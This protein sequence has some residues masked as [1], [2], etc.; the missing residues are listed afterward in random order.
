M[1]RC[2]C[3]LSEGRSPGDAHC[4]VPSVVFLAHCGIRHTGLF[5][6]S[7]SLILWGYVHDI[8]VSEKKQLTIQSLLYNSNFGTGMSV[9][10]LYACEY[11][12]RRKDTKILRV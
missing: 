10:M 4:F 12:V 7:L 6:S 1:L 9:D 11:E 5:K 3:G 2:D 8:L